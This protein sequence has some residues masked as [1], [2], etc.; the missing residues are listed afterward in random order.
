MNTSLE[1]NVEIMSDHYVERF[2]FLLEGEMLDLQVK[3]HK[4][5]YSIHQE[6]LCNDG[7]VEDDNYQWMYLNYLS[8]EAN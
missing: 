1:Q 7:E 4:D 6:Y 3:R 2:K 8:E 5:A